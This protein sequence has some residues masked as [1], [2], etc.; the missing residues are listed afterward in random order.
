VMRF[1]DDDLEQL[2]EMANDSEY[3][4][5]ANIWTSDLSRAHRLARRIR[6]GTI[7][8]N[9]AGMDPALP[10]G[11]FKQS[12]WGRENGLEGVLAYTELKSVAVR[13]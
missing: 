6:A 7:R 10:F 8:I 3:G 9:G 5:S 11:G 1:G 13:L 12:G 2:A 4:L